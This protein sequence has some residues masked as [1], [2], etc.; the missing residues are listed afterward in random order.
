MADKYLLYSDS[1]LVAQV[2]PFLRPKAGMSATEFIASTTSSGGTEA[3]CHTFATDTIADINQD[4]TSQQAMLDAVDNG[5]AAP[6][7][8]NCAAEGQSLVSTEQGNLAT[9][10]SN[11]ATAHQAA[12]DALTAKTTAC[13]ASVAFGVSLAALEANTCNDYT[14]QAAFISAKATCDSARAD[15]ATADAASHSA[16]TLATDAQ[17]ALDGAISEADR[18]S[19]ECNCRVQSEQAAAWSAIPGVVAAH[20][21]DWQQ[22]NEVLCALDQSTNTCQYAACPSVTQPTLGDGVAEDPC[23]AAAAFHASGGETVRL[24]GGAKVEERRA[25]LVLVED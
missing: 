22:A 5:S 19:T 17:T 16:Q 9:A 25:R 3:D 4:V 11:L 18:L 23:A 24:T 14:T 8:S 21:T 7:H 13:T 20:A 12:A 10:Q 15:L 6:G 1:A 2:Q